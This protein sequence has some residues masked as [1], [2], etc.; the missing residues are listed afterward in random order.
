[1]K[2]IVVNFKSFYKD[3]RNL[4]IQSLEDLDFGRQKLR[5]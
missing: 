5:R 1:M 4:E 3:I 2:M